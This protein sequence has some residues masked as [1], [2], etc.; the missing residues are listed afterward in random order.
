VD[1]LYKV[2]HWP[3]VVADI[4]RLHHGEP[5][6]HKPGPHEALEYSIY[7]MSFCSI[8]NEEA[9]RFGLGNRANLI[10]QYR[11]AAET[12]ISEAGLL[13][14][15]NVTSLQAF[16]IYLVRHISPPHLNHSSVH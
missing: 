4:R 12:A 3:T 15:P 11:I 5:D 10:E 13:H 14:Q 2:L 9:S 16:V 1:C 7:F 6:V 8:T